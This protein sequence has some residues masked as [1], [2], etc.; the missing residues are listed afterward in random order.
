MQSAR[1]CGIERPITELG[2]KITDS[3]SIGC[4]DPALAEFPTRALP[5]DQVI[6]PLQ[7]SHTPERIAQYRVAMERGERFPP[8][9]VVRIGR[10]FFVADG[11]KRF[12]AYQALP[13]TDILVEVWPIRRWLRDQWRQLRGKSRQQLTLLRRCV[14]DPR[15]RAQAARLMRDTIGHW[16]RIGRSLM[17]RSGRRG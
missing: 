10:R 13:V 1:G 11:H 4:F 15:G 16:R 12:S 17:Q 14:R 9:A 6:D 3:G 5:I 8:I 7:V 2:D